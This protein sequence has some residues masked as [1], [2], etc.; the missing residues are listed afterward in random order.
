[1]PAGDVVTASLAALD[2]GEVVCVPGLSDAGAVARLSAAELGLRDGA[3]TRV[4]PR[5]GTARTARD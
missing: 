4:A 3:G 5:C 2:D 1:M